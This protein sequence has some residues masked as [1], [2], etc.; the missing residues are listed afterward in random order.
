ML[1]QD[2]EAYSSF[3][4]RKRVMR[5]PVRQHQDKRLHCAHFGE[6]FELLHGALLRDADESICGILQLLLG[7][8]ALAH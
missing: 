4:S 5:H 6:R 1:G 3:F 2:V 8:A 7:A